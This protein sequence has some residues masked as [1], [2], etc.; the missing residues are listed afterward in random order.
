MCACYGVRNVSFSE[1]WRTYSMNDPQGRGLLRK[2]FLK[3]STKTFTTKRKEKFKV[4]NANL[5][6]TFKDSFLI[7][8]V[9]PL[10]ID[11]YFH[12]KL[13]QRYTYNIPLPLLYIFIYLSIF[14]I[15]YLPNDKYPEAYLE[16]S[17]ISMM[18]LFCENS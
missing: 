5:S 4:N 18:E 2:L 10:L 7:Y 16:P 3:S 6:A 12:K 8:I 15:V 9:R 17:R 14:F 11:N 1:I 13:H